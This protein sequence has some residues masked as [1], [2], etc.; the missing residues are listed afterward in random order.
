MKKI[1]VMKYF[2]LISF[3]GM[4]T[5]SAFAQDEEENKMTE[6]LIFALDTIRRRFGFNAIRVGRNIV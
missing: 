3:V 4:I 5:L 1:N 2:L 6:S